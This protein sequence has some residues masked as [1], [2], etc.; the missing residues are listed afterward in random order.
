MGSAAVVRTVVGT[1]LAAGVIAAAPAVWW[2]AGVLPEND[3]G[4]ASL[5]YAITP[6]AIG[7]AAEQVI[8]LVAV[9]VL[10]V[11]AVAL[12]SGTRADLLARGGPR[13]PQR[14]L[15]LQGTSA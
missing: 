3:L 12:G 2:L 6:P 5:D 8:G 9:T 4:G 1:V 11:A 10:L 13:S 7:S 15:S 14:R